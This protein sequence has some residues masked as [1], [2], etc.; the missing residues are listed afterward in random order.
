MI[1][2]E[3]I[4]AA[5]SDDDGLA[6]VLEDPDASIQWTLGLR[7]M[8]AVHG[9]Q[10]LRAPVPPFGSSIAPDSDVEVY[11]LEIYG[12]VRELSGSSI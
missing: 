3:R 7:E 1:H 11:L 2:I 6:P 8:V 9:A 10:Q 5:S 4:L 12:L